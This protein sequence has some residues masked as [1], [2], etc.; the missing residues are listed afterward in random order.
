[1]HT[2]AYPP[3]FVTNAAGYLSERN[4]KD[5]YSD[6]KRK[7]DHITGFATNGDKREKNLKSFD[8]TLIGSATI[9]GKLFRLFHK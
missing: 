4:W 1:L 5:M 8:K 7:Y 2:L 6:M 9:A 3:N